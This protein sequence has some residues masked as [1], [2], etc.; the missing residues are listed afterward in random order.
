MM[1]VDAALLTRAKSDVDR[2]VGKKELLTN[3]LQ[4]TEARI[5]FNE[6]LLGRIIKLRVIIQEVGEKT[7]SNLAYHVSN[8]VSSA[9]AVIPFPEPIEFEAEFVRARKGVECNLWFVRNGQR[10]IP[11]DTSGGGALDIASFALRLTYWSLK[12]NRSTIILDEPFKFVSVNL[13]PRCA[14]MVKELSEKLKLQIIMISHLPNI[15]MTADREYEVLKVRQ[16]SSV[17]P[18]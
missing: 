12:K 5:E 14:E 13:Q 1:K 16:I 17:L 11:I 8:L 6:K 15:N 4:E 9:L 10:S 3:Q 2:L 7:L 18:K